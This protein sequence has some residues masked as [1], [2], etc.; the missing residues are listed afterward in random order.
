M[1]IA[2]TID[3]LSRYKAYRHR[4]I[5]DGKRVFAQMVSETSIK[6]IDVEDLD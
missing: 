6:M 3:L 2:A 1:T 4:K 5:T